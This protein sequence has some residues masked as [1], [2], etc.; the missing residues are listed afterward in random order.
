MFYCKI[1]THAQMPVK[2]SYYIE[3]LANLILAVRKIKY[4]SSHCNGNKANLIS[5][6]KSLIFKIENY[7]FLAK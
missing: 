5:T 6:F 3:M 1:C 7:F 4:I 2:N